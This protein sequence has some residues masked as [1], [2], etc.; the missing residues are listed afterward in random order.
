ML[1][2]VVRTLW[3]TKSDVPLS[4]SI[5]ELALLLLRLVTTVWPVVFL[6]AVLKV[7]QLSIVTTEHV[8]LLYLHFCRASAA[9]ETSDVR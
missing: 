2:S 8:F 6:S 9:S 5:L 4:T 7:A 3:G 1:S